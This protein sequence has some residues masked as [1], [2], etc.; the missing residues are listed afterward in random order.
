MN[1]GKVLLGVLAG[2]AVGA[3]AG[4]L[5]APDKGSDTRKKLTKKSNDYVDE[6]KNKFSEFIESITE[7]ITDQAETAMD[8]AEEL[9]KNGK[10]K[11]DQATRS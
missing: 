11:A 7:T 5:L 1:S 2:I 3:V 6:L 10:S 9:V 4:I 8:E